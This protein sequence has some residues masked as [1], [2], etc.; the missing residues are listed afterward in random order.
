LT[1]AEQADNQKKLASELDAFRDRHQKLLEAK[2]QIEAEAQKATY[3][4][5]T[6]LAAEAEKLAV[7]EKLELDFDQSVLAAG[8]IA[9]AA[10]DGSL[11]GMDA[12]LS[13]NDASMPLAL[14]QTASGGLPVSV[15]RRLRQCISL[16][17]ELMSAQAHISTLK[18]RIHALQVW[19]A[20]KCCNRH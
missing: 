6:K 4:L 16:A 13:G 9:A 14:L 10:E 8:T 12:V 19:F 1:S 15:R 20:N 18:T 11:T 17:K 3:L 2:L 5:E 7:Y